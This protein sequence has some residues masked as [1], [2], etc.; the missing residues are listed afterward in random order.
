MSLKF[1]SPLIREIA[2]LTEITRKKRFLSYLTIAIVVLVTGSVTLLSTGVYLYAVNRLQTEFNENMNARKGRVEVM[3]KNR[4]DE[5]TSQLRTVG[6]DNTVRF[7][8]QKALY[9][10][11]GERL[12]HFGENDPSVYF[13]VQDKDNRLICPKTGDNPM[14][15]LA[16]QVSQVACSEIVVQNIQKKSNSIIWQ[17]SVP[18]MDQSTFIGS[19]FVLYDIVQD[20]PF[21]KEM[22]RVSQGEIVLKKGEAFFDI[23]GGAVSLMSTGGWLKSR[24]NQ[25]YISNGEHILLAPLKRFTGLQFSLSQE[26]LLTEKKNILLILSLFTVSILLVSTGLSMFLGRQMS[27]P[28]GDMADMAIQISCGKKDLSFEVNE[29][30]FLEFNQLSQAFNYM[31]ENLKEAEERSRFTQLLEN[32]DDAVYLTDAYGGLLEAN[33]ATY[34]ILGHSPR[35]FSS[36]TLPDIMPVNDARLVLDRLPH[37]DK[38]QA[39]RLTFETCLIRSDKSVIP[40][41]IKA[42]SISFNKGTAILHVARDITQRI[43]SQRILRESEEL[44]RSL[45]ETSHTGIL[46]LDD[47]YKMTYANNRLFQIMGYSREE[48]NALDLKPI[49]NLPDLLPAPVDGEKNSKQGQIKGPLEIKIVSKDKDER[50]C[51]I[52]TTTIADSSEKIRIMVQLMDITD[53]YRAEQEKMVLESHLRQSQKMEAIGNLASGVAHDFNNLLQIIHGYTEIVMLKKDKSSADYPK[54]LEI[55]QAAHRAT[56][57]T[58]QLLIFSRK[59]ESV[60]KPTDLNHEVTQIHTLIKR[61]FPKM[62]DIELDLSDDLQVINADATQLSQIIMNLCVNA[63]DAMPEGGKL[64]IKTRKQVIDQA[65]CDNPEG[66]GFTPGAYECLIISDTGLGMSEACLEHIYEP[67]YTTKEIGK[68]TGLGLSIVYGIINGHDG[69]IRCKSEPGAGTTFE[70]YFPA[71]KNSLKKCRPVMR[72]NPEAGHETILLVDDD[73]KVRD[74]GKEMLTGIGYHVLTAPDGESAL[75]I[76]QSGKNEIDLVVLDI[77]MPGIG[78]HKCLER[79]LEIDPEVKVLMT[80]GHAT[81]PVNKPLEAKIKGFIPKPFYLNQ[82]SETLRDIL[83]EAPPDS[84]SDGQIGMHRGSGEFTADLPEKRKAS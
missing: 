38:N 26:N 82:I 43:E 54:L 18:I 67:F 81:H 7:T 78:G 30:H 76:Y 73:E 39:G 84:L 6:M 27:R 20:K 62:I 34:A 15:G 64:T 55:K 56:D 5:I 47:R 11:L 70:I 58:R 25:T 49:L 75:E 80:S 4:I 32:V 12:K 52:N 3:L 42:R 13:Y 83:D 50:H 77:L 24:T 57:L 46:I 51:F 37:D 69:H 48:M 22:R 35:A 9:E 41:E 61:T 29:N 71:V 23:N 10:E 66:T 19:A 74:I 2:G 8:T 63:R 53:Q 40:V 65:F 1:A 59:V 31:L 14:E 16:D 21:T 79:L 17:F 68:G 45:I 60:M 33:A 36:L 72:K 28:L 44:Y